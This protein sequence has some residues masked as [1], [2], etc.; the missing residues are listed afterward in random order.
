MLAAVILVS[1]RRRNYVPKV[2]RV[3]DTGA[4]GVMRQAKS[5]PAWEKIIMTAMEDLEPTHKFLFLCL[6][7]WSIRIGAREHFRIVPQE[8]YKSNAL[9]YWV[10]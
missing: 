8:C 6:A 3:V 4:I 1:A 10:L 9:L 7:E 5:I 2:M